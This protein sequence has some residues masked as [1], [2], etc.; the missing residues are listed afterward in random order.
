MSETDRPAVLFHRD[1]ALWL[2]QRA[3][4]GP[5]SDDLL[6][7]G[8]VAAL[9]VSQAEQATD[10]PGWITSRVTLDLVRPVPRAPLEVE[11]EVLRAGRRVRLVEISVRADGREVVHARVQRTAHEQIAL[12][13]SELPSVRPA[14]PPDLPEDFIGPDQYR[15]L[16]RPIPFVEESSE[17]RVPDSEGP[18]GTGAITAWVRIQAELLPGQRLSP[19]ASVCAAGDFTH[20]FGSPEPVHAMRLY[21]PNADLSVH[22]SRTPVDAW[23]RMA[24]SAVWETSGVGHAR[25]ELSDRYGTIGTS[26][27]TLVLS[28]P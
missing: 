27:M 21:F 6:H 7:G 10:D 24:P 25:C 18:F 28:T 16:A 8:A 23:V 3:C 12:L 15:P 26:V 4:V 11:T 19:A 22:L 14:P 13:E 2:P 5:W 17:I 9:C 20:A 1:D